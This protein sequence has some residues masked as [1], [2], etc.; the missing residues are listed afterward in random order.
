[1]PIPP[2]R[3]LANGLALAAFLLLAGAPD[4]NA[5]I[6]LT[7]RWRI[8]STKY[9]DIVQTGSGVVVAW[10]EN[11]GSGDMALTLTGTFN[12]TTLSATD[13]NF[14]LGMLMYGPGNV[15]DG[16]LGAYGAYGTEHRQFTRCECWDGNLDNGDGCDSECLVEPCFTCTPEPS[17]CTPSADGASC[18]DRNDCTTGEQC[19]AGT[20]DGGTV[21][22]PCVNMEGMWR[23]HAE[24]TDPITFQVV[25]STFDTQYRQRDAVVRSIGGI[26]MID[27]STGDV[28]L[29]NRGSYYTCS[30]ASDLAITASTDNMTFAAEGRA[31]WPHIRLC[32]SNA[33]TQSGARCHDTLGC[34][35]TDCT[36]LPD[37]TSCSNGDPCTWRQSCS[38]GVCTGQDPIC[39]ACSTCTGAGVCEQVPRD[40][41]SLSTRP[42]MGRFQFVDHATDIDKQS[43][44]WM[45]KNGPALTVADFGR[46]DLGDDLSLCVFRED[47]SSLIYKETLS[48]SA[49]CDEPPCWEASSNRLT[50]RPR[51]ELPSGLTSISMRGGEAGRSSIQIRGKGASLYDSALGFLSTPAPLPLRTQLQVGNGACFEMRFTAD[52][53]SKN[54]DGV[55]K[56]KGN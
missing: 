25:K 8:S 56:A 6:D 21:T 34:S 39:P 1:M 46:P 7:G 38:A 47:D 35:L 30:L 54:A 44:K 27:I 51:G 22:A 48:G 26:G 41:C 12:Q 40:D 55:F 5:D 11:F 2:A 3:R 16:A 13:G 50:Y 18:D 14:Q 31:Y 49:T 36:G 4:A 15:L 33:V 32:W 53:V 28:E 24:V 37:G 9:A 29:V 10:T 20:C 42:D 19:S 23:I 17:V 43:L 52:G 45:W